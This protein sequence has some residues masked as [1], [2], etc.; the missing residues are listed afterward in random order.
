MRLSPK[1]ISHLN[2][3]FFSEDKKKDKQQESFDLVFSPFN[4]LKTDGEPGTD[5]ENSFIQVKL[6]I[7]VIRKLCLN[8]PKTQRM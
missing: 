5:L 7:R 2:S 6:E 1:N 4:T 8:Q 3:H